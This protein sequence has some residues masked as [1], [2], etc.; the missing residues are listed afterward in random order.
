MN[1]STLTE[2][3]DELGDLMRE[4]FGRSKDRPVRYKA[5]F[6]LTST[7]ASLLTDDDYA[8]FLQAAL[9]AEQ[10]RKQPGQP[11]GWTFSEY[12]SLALDREVGDLDAVTGRREAWHVMRAVHSLLPGDEFTSFIQCALD[13]WDGALEPLQRVP[14]RG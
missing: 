9:H 6:S 1:S 5:A 14:A 7:T 2:Y 12:F 13:A 11:V 4:R 10:K 3:R 8:G